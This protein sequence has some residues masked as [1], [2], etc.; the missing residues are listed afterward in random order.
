MKRKLCETERSSSDQ[1]KV[2]VIGE[3]EDSGDTLGRPN[4]SNSD[5]DRALSETLSKAK[6]RKY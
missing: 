5:L 4:E 3:S 1:G 2:I 6:S